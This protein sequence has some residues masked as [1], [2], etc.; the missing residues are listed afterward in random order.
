MNTHHS[1]STS[2]RE[3][4]SAPDQWAKRKNRTAHRRLRHTVDRSAGVVVWVGGIAT[5][6]SIMGI[7]LYLMWEVIPLFRSTSGDL[8]ATVQVH[9][10]RALPSNTTVIGSDEYQEVVFVLEENRLQFLRM[11]QGTPVPEIEGEL[12]I[13]GTVQSSVL[14]GQKGNRVSLATQEGMVVPVTIHFRP[15][16]EGTNRRIMPTHQVREPIRVIPVGEELILHAHTQQDERQVIA[17]VT[18]SGELWLTQLEE[19]GEFSFSDEV[20]ITQRQLEIP[21]QTTITHMVLDGFGRRLVAGT[22]QGELLEWLLKDGA[23]TKVR[24]VAVGEPGEV[25]TALNYLLGERTLIVGTQKGR[26]M[27]WVPMNERKGPSPIPFRKVT[28]F[29]AHNGA[30]QA[31][32]PSQRDKGFL[33]ADSQGHVILHHATTGQTVLEFDRFSMETTALRFSPKANGGVWLGADGRLKTFSIDNPHPEVTFRSLFFPV[34]YEGYEDP[35]LIWQSS[36]GSDEFEPKFGMMPLIFGTLKGTIYAMIL[37]VPLAVMGAV[38]TAMFMHPHLRAIVKPGIE[39]MAALPSVVLGF[40]A[41]LWFAP[42]LEKIFP[43]VVA[44]TLSLPVVIGLVCLLWQVLPRSLTGLDKYG[45]DLLVIT[46]AVLATVGL[47]LALNS[48][49]EAVVFGGNYKQWLTD[50]FGLVYDQRNAIVISF[51]MGFA[52]IP[53]IFSIAED[54][55]SNVPRHLVAGSLALGATQWQ[56][57]TRLVLVSASPGIFSALMIGFGRAVG[58]TMIVLMATGNTPILDWSIFNG[59]RTLSANIAVEMPEAPHGGTL[60]RV[61]FLS[62]LILFAFTF[63]INTMA[64]LIRQRLREKYSQF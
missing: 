64:E 52:V 21:E 29:Q 16:F 47:C 10:G 37:A 14:I 59:F 61:L 58:E 23:D 63:G 33:T 43:A 56:T 36:S 44:G 40:L 9:E 41:G 49:I 25:I 30:V 51:A 24:R 48:T 6:V 31:I 11:P 28:T 46:V 60:Y 34:I 3:I 22:K 4:L 1:V 39:I 54:S 5:I 19:P 12:K 26:V 38:Y 2:G 13:P 27:T 45:I 8:V 32:S 57:L 18:E 15:V 53:I 42:L 55:L 20:T 17:A 35:E 7:F 50:H 62:G